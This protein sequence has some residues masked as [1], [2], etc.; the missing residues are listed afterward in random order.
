[1]NIYKVSVSY[2]NKQNA[3]FTTSTSY[4]TYP[5]TYITQANSL[6]AALLKVWHHITQDPNQVITSIS[7]TPLV[8]TYFLQ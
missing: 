7:V 8:D 1:M 2:Y 4:I 3:C 6:D 5:V